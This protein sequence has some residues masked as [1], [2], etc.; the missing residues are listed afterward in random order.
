MVPPSTSTPAAEGQLLRHLS[1]VVYRLDAR[2][3][4][5]LTSVT[6]NVRQLIG[7]D[8]GSVIGDTGFTIGR[9]H[10]DDRASLRD[11]LAKLPAT[12]NHSAEYRF[13]HAD[14]QY[15]WLRDDLH[16]VSGT[17]GEPL[18][19]VG[20]CADITNIVESRI[21][22]ETD[23]PRLR[24]IVAAATSAIVT[25]DDLHH[26]RRGLLGTC[27]VA[28]SE[29]AITVTAPCPQVME[30][31]AGGRSLHMAKRIEADGTQVNPTTG[32]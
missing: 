23:A 15:M 8:P 26:L 2:S 1:V 10:P 32:R 9:A 27:R 31:H 12:E 6:D 20:T 19:A 4:Y 30:S 11:R 7:Y 18:H 5:R 22:G 21:Q 25:T 24:G 13:L 14:G 16:F 17:G 28:G 29:R 3:D